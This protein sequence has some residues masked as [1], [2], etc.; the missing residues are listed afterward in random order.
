MYAVIFTSRLSPDRSG[1]EEMTQRMLELCAQQPG[2][3]SAESVRDPDGRGITVCTWESLES[4]E[5]WGHEPEHVA[6]QE[7][8]RTR[9]YDGYHIM[10]C[11][12]L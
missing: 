7:E 11:K 3:I 5:A 10:V 12:V 8:G 6:A 9:W 2:F 4:I 1:Y